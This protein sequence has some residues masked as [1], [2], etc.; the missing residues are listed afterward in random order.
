MKGF[1]RKTLR[2]S[3][4]YYSASN[5][6]PKSDE[7]KI[8]IKEDDFDF[9]DFPDLDFLDMPTRKASRKKGKFKFLHGSKHKFN[10]FSD[11]FVGSPDATD[12]EGP[13]I[14]FT[15][16]IDDAKG[17]AGD[18]GIIYSVIINAENL[19]TDDSV[20]DLSYLSNDVEKL[21]SKSPLLKSVVK[22]Y[23]E[24]IDELVGSLIMKSRSEKE[25]F[26]NLY[27]ELYY[28]NPVLFVRTM[29]KMGYDGMYLKGKGVD[30]IVLYN[31]RLV[32]ILDAKQLF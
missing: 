4:E 7:Y 15:N 11:E 8:G 22:G 17:Y 19:I 2:E 24:G 31:P 28:N 1:I 23:D 5:A 14:Y 18:N 21:V 13:G 29:A 3:L 27:E 6:E 25:L 16:N 9:G 12:Q 20:G 30:N 26:V 10:K 32:K